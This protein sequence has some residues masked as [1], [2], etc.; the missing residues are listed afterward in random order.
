VP[1]V[2]DR[3]GQLARVAAHRRELGVE[4]GR[5][6]DGEVRARAPDQPQLRDD[7][8]LEALLGQQLREGEGVAGVGVDGSDRRLADGEV[9]GV[10]R[11]GQPVPVPLRRPG[12]HDLRSVATHLAG[13][14][15]PQG[16][17]GFELPVDEAE[18]AHRGDAEHPGGRVLL[19]P[20]DAG[21]RRARHRRVEPAGLPV[22]G[23]QQCDLGALR[24]EPRHRATTGEVHIV[25]MGGHD[26]HAARLQGYDHG[27]SSSAGERTLGDP[28]RRPP[29]ARCRRRSARSCGPANS[30]GR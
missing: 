6:V 8:R 15:A 21:Q 2:A 11:P 4:V 25:G 9:V 22:G 14:L 26:Q 27:S 18:V 19:L 10:A 5:D 24:H 16:Q 3:V 28:R 23:D 12:E 20:P 7:V 29:E 17:G 13:D 30:C 1:A